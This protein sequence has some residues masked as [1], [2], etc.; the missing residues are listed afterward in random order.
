[1]R[2]AYAVL[3]KGIIDE[4]PTEPRVI[5]ELV[6]RRLRKHWLG[7]Q[8]HFKDVVEGLLSVRAVQLAILAWWKFLVA[9][10]VQLIDKGP[11]SYRALEYTKA[12]RE[13]R[14][15]EQDKFSHEPSIVAKAKELL[16]DRQ[17]SKCRSDLI[18]VFLAIDEV[19]LVSERGCSWGVLWARKKVCR[20]CGVL[21]ALEVCVRVCMLFFLVAPVLP[22]TSCVN[23][24]PSIRFE[25][26]V[27]KSLVQW[28]DDPSHEVDLDVPHRR[29]L[30]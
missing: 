29:I 12:R 15:E 8:E 13:K 11:E 1:M 18:S 6:G 7:Q 28:L 5:V 20:Q 17:D 22:L 19:S 3:S 9:T 24:S 21:R 10:L 26:V 14:F 4:F 27:D 25:Q 16:P 30:L 2:Q 23:P